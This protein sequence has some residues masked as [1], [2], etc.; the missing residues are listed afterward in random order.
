MGVSRFAWLECI[1]KPVKSAILY[2]ILTIIFAG[3]LT[4]LRLYA[5][6]R[7]ARAEALHSIG[8][9]IQLSPEGDETAAISEEMIQRILELPYVIGVNQTIAGYA[10]PVGFSNVKEYEG[11]TP[12]PKDLRYEEA[13]DIAPGNVVVDANTDNR[14]L[15]VFRLN[16]VH[17]SE[18]IIPDDG[19]RGIMVE[20][21]LAQINHL[22]LGDKLTF[23]SSL[24][25]ETEAE[26]IGI[27]ETDAV[28]RITENNSLGEGIFAMS[29]YNRIYASLDVGEML[30]QQEASGQNLDI[31]IDAPEHVEATGKAVKEFPWDWERLSLY[32]MTESY[33]QDYA[34]HIESLGRTSKILLF[35]L[36]A[37][38]GVF[39][40]IVLTVFSHYY[41]YDSGILLSLGAGKRRIIGQHFL[42]TL[43]I[44]AAAMVTSIVFAYTA[45]EP[46]IEAVIDSSNRTFSLGIAQFSDGI[47]SDYR[48]HLGTLGIEGGLLYFAIVFLFL[49]LSCMS[50]VY[51]VIRFKPREILSEK[52]R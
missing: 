33:Y 21:R 8:S 17:V 41:D 25:V 4:G 52:R 13:Y 48:I 11:E 29:P 40:S 7:Q 51:H 47:S 35:Y 43:Y 42:S 14:F 6:T 10:V 19:H 23:T 1:R 9:Y 2:V 39:L 5:S 45:A 30:Y 34:G 16:Q 37:I 31:Y 46:W 24:N 3:A 18:G 50:P 49:G 27:Y 38:G 22:E 44:A 26:I 36:L 32:N 12:D 20:K 28:F 15:E